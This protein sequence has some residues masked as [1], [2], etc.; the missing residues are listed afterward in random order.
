MLMK[1]KWITYTTG[2]YKGID[3]KYGNPSPY[4]RK[5]FALSGKP[6]K[7]CLMISALGV[8]KAYFNGQAVSNDYLAPGWVD[9]RK[10]LPVVEYDITHLLQEKNAVGV[11]LG[12]GWAVGHVGS[13]FTFKRTSWNDTIEFTA[14]VRI[15][16]DDGTVE[17]IHTDDTWKATQGAIRRSDIYMGEYVDARLDPGDF[18]HPDYDDSAWDPVEVPAFKFTRN[19]FLKRVINPPIVV[20]HIL[21]PT[22]VKQEGN[23]FLYDVSQNMSGVVRCVFR[24]TRGTRIVIRH[25]ELLVDGALYT[26]NLRKAEATNTYILAGTGDE[27]FRPLF[28]FHGFRFFEIT[29]EGQ[30]EI[31]SLSAEVMYTDLPSAGTFS[32]SD[33]IVTKVYQNALWGQRGNFLDVPTDCPQR[34]ER[35]GWAGDAQVFCKSAMFNMDCRVFFKKYLHDL[36]DAQL[37]NGVVPIVAPLPSIG[38]RNYSGH[39]CTAGWAEC[40][41]ELPYFHYLMYGDKTVIRD[42]LPAIKKLLDY[43]EEESPGRVR[44]YLDHRYGDWLNCNAVMDQS[45]VATMYYARA[46]WDAAQLGRAIGDFEA[47]RYE[48]LYEEIREAFRKRFV[49]ADGRIFSDTQSCYLMGYAFGLI[50]ADEARENLRRKLKED[51]GHLTSG[52]LGIKFLLPVLCELGMTEDAYR[53]LTYRDFPGWCYSV[54]HGATTIWE[55]WDSFTVEKGIRP[56]MNSFNHYSLGSCTEWMY[57]Y[58][59]GIHPHFEAP[60]FRKVTFRPFPDPTGAITWAKGHYDTDFGR[61]EAAWEANGKQVAYRVTVPAAIENHFDFGAMTVVS[62]TRNGNEYEFVLQ[63]P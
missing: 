37:G 5:A 60:G 32:C 12:D 33:P 35:L 53:I 6:Q 38:F 40:I 42:N 43:Y 51:D 41:A 21:E 16:Y 36:R 49:E 39:D 45:V 3:D 55:H 20:K 1:S 8:F 13:N 19:T 56:G 17:E 61:I 59:L 18:S 50:S 34:D 63:Q 26:E 46:A 44:D 4:F 22:L 14:L 28:T 31:V 9:Y 48:A 30:A 25:G 15:T 29:V 10:Q 27:T 7:A 47:D 11:V 54:R 57:E 24:G 58:C 62:E 52:F 2:D 23:R